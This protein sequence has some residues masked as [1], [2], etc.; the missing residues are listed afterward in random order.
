MCGKSSVKN[1]DPKC[2]YVTHEVGTYQENSAPK[3]SNSG[4]WRRYGK[5]IYT[6]AVKLELTHYSSGRQLGVNYPMGVISGFLGV[7]RPIR[8]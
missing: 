7:T 6:K 5:I 2:T 4:L 8:K 1:R 3:K